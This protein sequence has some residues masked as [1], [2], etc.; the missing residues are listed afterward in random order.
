MQLQ[1]PSH[2]LFRG[3]TAPTVPRVKPEERKKKRKKAEKKPGINVTKT[4]TAGSV[5]ETAGDF[6]YVCHAGETP[7][8]VL[9]T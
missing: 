3:D 2:M 7:L 5:F 1:Q 9:S 6:V 8:K 4:P